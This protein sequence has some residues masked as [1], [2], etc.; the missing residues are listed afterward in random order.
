MKKIKL[1]GIMFF[2]SLCSYFVV[3]YDNTIRTVE[4]LSIFA[5][6]AMGGILGIRIEDYLKNKRDA[7]SDSQAENN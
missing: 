2:L 7:D 4:F 1:I 3:I 5:A 6:G